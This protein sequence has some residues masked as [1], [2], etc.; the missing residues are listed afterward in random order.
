MTV[1]ELRE[2]FNDCWFCIACDSW[3]DDYA[4]WEDED[5]ISFEQYL[6]RKVKVCFPFVGLCDFL[7]ICCVIEE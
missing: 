4:I 1:R 6:D 2:I 5:S 3:G 7:Y